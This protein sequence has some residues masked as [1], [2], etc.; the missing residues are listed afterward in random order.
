[1]RR[2]GW[3]GCQ[4]RASWNPKVAPFFL[5]L[6]SS[7]LMLYL[8]GVSEEPLS[9][10]RSLHKAES[11]VLCMWQCW[12]VCT[13]PSL[14]KMSLGCGHAGTKG[15]GEAV[16]RPDSH[17]CLFHSDCP[18]LTG[19]SQRQGLFMAVQS[20]LLSLQDQGERPPLLVFRASVCLQPART[21]WYR[22]GMDQ[23]SWG[24]S[25]SPAPLYYGS[26]EELFGLCIECW[27]TEM[28]C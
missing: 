25:S 17:L 7:C 20:F 15:R 6:L 16:A 13:A 9:S 5:T 1:M 4:S 28:V 10:N 14:C 12:W 22:W 19:L 23:N 11:C 2:E 8:L 26:L 21:R 27:A 24:F 18:W 3:T